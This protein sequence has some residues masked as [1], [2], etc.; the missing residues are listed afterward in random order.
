MRRKVSSRLSRRRFV[1][2]ATAVAAA[3]TAAPLRVRAAG[4]ASVSVY[5]WEA[6]IGEHT[7]DTFARR[8]GIAVAYDLY[9][10]NEELFASLR[11]GNPGYDVIFP[12]DYMVETMISLNMLTPLDH[13]SIPNLRHIDRDPNFSD[14]PFNRR[15]RFGVPYMWGT[16]GIG[17]RRSAL[18]RAPDSWAWIFDEAKSEAFEGRIAVLNDRR[19]MIGVALKYLGYSMNSTTAREIVEARDL[20]IRAKKN[21]RTFA[22]D[23]GQDLLLVGD[24]DIAVEWNGDIGRAQAND[25]DIGYAVPREGSMLW[26]DNVCIPR[27]APHA[28][29]AHAFINH[30]LD[31][32]VNAEIANFVHFATANATAR[33]RINPADLNDPIVYAPPW[34]VAR[35]EALA[36]VG[37][38]RRLYDEAWTAILAA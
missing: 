25:G 5:N 22:P 29:N 3:L 7:L 14:P 16:M 21:I 32:A 9:A 8:T 13:G 10:N 18:D 4:E 37:E 11:H 23:S 34:L 33:E 36:D 27:S 12:S 2:G 31:P 17:Y 20:L 15:L 26:M 28:R 1:A 19:V 38:Y 24:V 35:C 6:Y 30:L